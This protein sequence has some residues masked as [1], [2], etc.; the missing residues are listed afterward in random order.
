[1]PTQEELQNAVWRAQLACDVFAIPPGLLIPE[2]QLGRNCGV[3][4]KILEGIEGAAAGTGNARAHPYDLFFFSGLSPAL[5]YDLF[6]SMV[7][8]GWE[9]VPSHEGRRL[10]SRRNPVNTLMSSQLNP[11]PAYRRHI[12]DVFSEGCVAIGTF[13]TCLPHLEVPYQKK[14]DC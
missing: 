5:T 13:A 3:K 8:M 6:E 10:K 1:M 7:A 2:L 12:A 4:K 9:R 11:K 14:K